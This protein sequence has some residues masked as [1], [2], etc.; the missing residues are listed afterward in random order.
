MAEET[1]TDVQSTQYETKAR[2]MG[3]KP[4]EE[5][6]GSADKW[7]DAKTFVDR[8]EQFLPI[9]KAENRRLKEQ[10]EHIASQNQQFQTELSG[11]RESIEGLK[12]F[13][14]EAAA[15]ELK[16]ERRKLRAELIAARK[17]GDTEKELS[18]QEQLDDLDDKSQQGAGEPAAKAAAATTSAT[19]DDPTQKPEFQ[20]FLRENS[21]FNDDPVMRAASLAIMQDAAAKGLL[22][23]MTPAQRFSY[24]AAETKKKFRM[25]DELPNT[26]K[27]SGSTGPTG[28]GGDG[29]H[30]YSALPADAK[31]ACDRFA[32]R[33]VGPGKAFKNEADWRKHY[34]QNY[35]WSQQ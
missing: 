5:F 13:N 16:A 30:S 28:A 20:Q 35:D 21:W 25:E 19:A 22:A 26:S 9:V 18:V 17:E 15:A 24:A 6:P 14:R 33:M 10:L 7:V 1:Q 3:W 29:G 32:K 27:V 2:E 4:R 31:A 12:Q 23:N 11:A 8:G 34:T